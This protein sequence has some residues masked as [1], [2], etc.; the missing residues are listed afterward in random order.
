[1]PGSFRSG[2]RTVSEKWP[3]PSDMCSNAKTFYADSPWFAQ[4]LTEHMLDP[5]DRASRRIVGRA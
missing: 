3:A 2:A 1:M 4:I 5:E